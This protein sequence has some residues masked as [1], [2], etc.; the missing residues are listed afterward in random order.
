[1][2]W[3]SPQANC[4]LG[5][6]GNCSWDE[7]SHEHCLPQPFVRLLAGTEVCRP[8]WFGDLTAQ[9]LRFQ[10]LRTLLSPGLF[11][12]VGIALEIFQSPPLA[13]WNFFASL[14]VLSSSSHLSG[15]REKTIIFLFPFFCL[16]FEDYCSVF[17]QSPPIE[18]LQ[19][20]SFFPCMPCFLELYLFSLLP[21]FPKQAYNKTE[22]S[23]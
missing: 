1:M 15:N 3:E 7:P 21:A 20:F 22:C 16:I 6:C 23:V 5:L 19:I 12:S 18:Q 8:S 2:Q 9:M 14:Q 13:C 17:H 11:T 4:S 10:W